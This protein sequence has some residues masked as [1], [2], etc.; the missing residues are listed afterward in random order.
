[1]KAKRQKQRV[2]AR[3]QKEWV[4]AKRRKQWVEV[5][6]RKQWMEAKRRGT[7]AVG[8]S[9]ETRDKSSEWWKPRDK[10]KETRAVSG[11]VVFM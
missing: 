1:M 4:E 10:T 7:T 11:S 8:G 9:Q 2:K 6:R 5:K 3:R